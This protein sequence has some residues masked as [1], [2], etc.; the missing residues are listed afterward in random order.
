[1][2]ISDLI[3]RYALA[4]SLLWSMDC[5][6]RTANTSNARTRPC[7]A[8][9]IIDS[10][11]SCCFHVP[12]A[13]LLTFCVSLFFRETLSRIIKLPLWQFRRRKFTYNAAL[14]GTL[15]VCQR[16]ASTTAVFRYG[17]AES[18]KWNSVL[19]VGSTDLLLGEC[20]V[21]AEAIR[22]GR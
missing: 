19:V 15:Q 21:E 5:D 14:S 8:Q 13:I 4:S 7:I 2:R 22:L 1:M 3:C 20:C 11:L 12:G 10:W 17:Y 9:V 16:A 18:G 6:V